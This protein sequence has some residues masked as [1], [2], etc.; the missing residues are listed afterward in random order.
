MCQGVPIFNTKDIDPL[1]GSNDQMNR[2]YLCLRV[3]YYNTTHHKNNA[4]INFYETFSYLCV[5]L[6]QK[7]WR[8]YRNFFLV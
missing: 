1:Q 7:E 3:L 8:N 5:K 6:T 4:S 2:S